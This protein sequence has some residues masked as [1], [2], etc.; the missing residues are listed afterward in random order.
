MYP[1]FENKKQRKHFEIGNIN[2]LK[3]YNCNFKIP[4][5]NLTNKH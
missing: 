4:K 1:D 2:V 3:N 5:K